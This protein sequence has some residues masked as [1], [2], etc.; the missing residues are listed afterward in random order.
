MIGLLAATGDVEG[1]AA[2]AA[3]S[4]KLTRDQ[5]EDEIRMTGSTAA[6]A[7]MLVSTVLGQGLSAARAWQTITKTQEHVAG[8]LSRSPSH[9]ALAFN[10]QAEVG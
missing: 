5:L 1:H 9:T 4:G 3:D 7:E 8:V 2:A 10:P 6:R